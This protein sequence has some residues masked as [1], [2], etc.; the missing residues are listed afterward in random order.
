M[1]GKREHTRCPSG[2]PRVIAVNN[3]SILHDSIVEA[4][5]RSNQCSSTNY[6]RKGV[7]GTEAEEEKRTIED[8]AC[9]CHGYLGSIDLCDIKIWFSLRDKNWD[10][11]YC[12]E[13]DQTMNRQPH[14]KQL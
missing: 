1:I 2:P 12:S 3:S 13:G 6:F 14:K 8:K 4:G 5:R 11:S 10:I 9:T 7:Y